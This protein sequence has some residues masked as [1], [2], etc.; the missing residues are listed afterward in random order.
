[1]GCP[2][3]EVTVEVTY[4]GLPVSANDRAVLERGTET[5]LDHCNG[6]SPWLV[7]WSVESR[8][9]S[10]DLPPRKSGRSGYGS[11][12]TARPDCPL[13]RSLVCTAAD[14]RRGR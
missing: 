7:T 6:L 10:V 12:A 8:Q 13:C 9:G 3:T 2:T 14:D 4:P 11:D 5:P 1:V